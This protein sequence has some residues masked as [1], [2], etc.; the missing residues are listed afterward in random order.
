MQKVVRF[1][2]YII[3]MEKALSILFKHLFVV[4]E[5][6]QMHTASKKDTPSNII[7]KDI[8]WV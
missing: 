8:N 5:D 4:R 1:N 7:L 3:N 6:H 2:I